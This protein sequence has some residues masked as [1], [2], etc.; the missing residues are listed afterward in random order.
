MRE[1]VIVSTARTPIGR[2]YRGAFN[3][4][5]PQE[6]VG[7]AVRHAVERAERAASSPVSGVIVTTAIGQMAS[8]RLQTKV[9][10]GARPVDD[11]D[12]GDAGQRHIAAACDRHLHL[13]EQ[14]DVAE[15]TDTT[16]TC[17]Y[18]AEQGAF[19]ITLPTHRCSVLPAPT[20]VENIA[21]WLA[22]SIAE[23][24]QQETHV[25]AFEGIN[26][27]ATAQAAP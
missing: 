7:H 10:L 9:S 1:A 14:A 3:D 26:K 27:G 23:Q 12:I 19:S 25:E 11:A 4:T 15:Q 2:A 5:Q 21:R 24:T 20:T 16:L 18:T 17:R 8:H 13:L 22:S 6:L